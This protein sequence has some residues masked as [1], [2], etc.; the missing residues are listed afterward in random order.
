MPHP[1]D[2]AVGNRVRELRTR[3]GLSQTEL[4]VQL[5]VSFQQ[6]QKYEKGTNRMG[7]SR[8][9]QVCEA[10][11]ITIADIFDGIGTARQA[12]RKALVDP[13][14]MRIAR[15]VQAI[16]DPQTRMALRTLVKSISSM[17]KPTDG[18]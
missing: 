15:E 5:G 7:A 13:E 17:Q 14:V 1:V 18:E 11:S 16:S 10:L 8:L 6:I 12:T 2:I 3:A 4:G 9:I